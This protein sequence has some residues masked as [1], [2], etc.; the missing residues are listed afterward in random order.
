M[1]IKQSIQS[2]AVTMGLLLSLTN[3]A[4][5]TPVIEQEADVAIE[6]LYHNL[7][8]MPNKSMAER[9]DWI[10]KQ[11]IGVPY[12]LGS[13][14]EGAHARY[15]Q[16]PKYRVDSFD[17]DTYVNTV[18]GLALG[19]SLA[20]FQN[21]LDK[22]RYKN[23]T[24][25][26]IYRNHFTDLDWNINNQRIGV[27]KDITGDIKDE[28]GQP[29]ALTAIALIDKPGWYAHRTLDTIRLVQP[30][31]EKQVKRL[32]ELKKKGKTL[33]AVEA[34]ID[35]LPFSALFSAQGKPNLQLFN[36]IPNAAVIE[37]IRPNWDLRD[38]IGTA[39]NVSHLGF[40]IWKDNV[41]YFRQA[42]S[43]AMKVVDV[44]L[45]DYLKQA[46]NSPTIKGIHIEVVNETNP[47]T[48]FPLHPSR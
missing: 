18:I 35:Y 1:N 37:I 32:K 31:S 10:S 22:I 5:N 45:I 13:L 42:S 26:Y 9:I 33:E 21:S 40:A 41:L 17:C 11:F 43:V 6:K 24:T 44:P 38:K 34:K 8:A 19:H 36:Q 7:N 14:G 46:M 20:S 2:I 3:H 23:A 4:V 30:D 48:S 28:Q 25:S 12:V 39:M 16:F 29:V 15:D 27:L 47:N